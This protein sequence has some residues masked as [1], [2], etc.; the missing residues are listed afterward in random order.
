LSIGLMYFSPIE[1]LYFTTKAK[2]AEH[3]Y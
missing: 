1:R 3:H 2:E